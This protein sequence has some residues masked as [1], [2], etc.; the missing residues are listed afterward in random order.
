MKD[1]EDFK[2]EWRNEIKSDVVAYC[3]HCG[4]TGPWEG[5]ISALNHEERSGE[6]TP[7]NCGT[8]HK[9]FSIS[10]KHKE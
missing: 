1:I 8:C 6:I 2:D 10:Y 4:A 9:P 5:Y 7:T 3:N